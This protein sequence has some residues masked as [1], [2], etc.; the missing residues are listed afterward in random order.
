MIPISLCGWA[1]Q[2]DPVGGACPA[3]RGRGIRGRGRGRGRSVGKKRTF[4]ETKDQ[5]RCG[6]MLKVNSIALRAFTP[7]RHCTVGRCVVP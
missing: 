5:H 1:E 7:P 3:A 6:I 4:D 2:A